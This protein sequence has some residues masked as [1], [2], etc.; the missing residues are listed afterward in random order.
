MSGSGGSLRKPSVGAL[1]PDSTALP[2]HRRSQRPA[3]D[4]A[5]VP[6]DGGPV[7]T[8]PPDF[9]SPLPRQAPAP[10]LRARL[11]YAISYEILGIFVLRPPASS[12]RSP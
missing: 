9:L 1:G 12:V 10:T 5:G 8:R 4:P 2:S 11:V 3:S 6:G 7:A